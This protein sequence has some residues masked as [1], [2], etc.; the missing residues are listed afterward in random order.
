[1]K[2][3]KELKNL[4]HYDFT[5]QDNFCKSAKQNSSHSHYFSIWKIH[6]TYA[7]YTTISFTSK[8]KHLLKCER[9]TQCG[10]FQ[11]Y[12]YKLP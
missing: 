8:D 1:M 9:L 2:I 4:L 5:L 10:L 11:I 6:S 12:K 3:G 7:Q